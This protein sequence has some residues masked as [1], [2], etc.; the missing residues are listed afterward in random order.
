LAKRLKAGID[1]R[2][3][4]G[5]PRSRE[6]ADAAGSAGARFRKKAR[7]TPQGPP[8]AADGPT[9]SREP[10]PVTAVDL[11]VEPPP[12]GAPTSTP[13]QGAGRAGPEGQGKAQVG[14]EQRADVQ[15]TS[16]QVGRVTPD[17]WE[18]ELEESVG[19]PLGDQGETESE[20]H[21]AEAEGEEIVF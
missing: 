11:T 13:S 1:H 18:D 3:P 2:V 4:E 6:E 16:R 7:R 20:A 14:G 9:G 12:A 15:Q 5:A 21:S 8:K 17:H 10:G 19:D